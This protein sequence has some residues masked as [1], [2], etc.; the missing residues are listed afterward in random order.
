MDE[1]EETE[2]QEQTNED[3]EVGPPLLTPLSED[4]ILNE[5]TPWITR[6]SSRFIPHHAFSSIHSCLWW[7]AHAYATSR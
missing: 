1:T 5:V 4:A 6:L 7:G 2:E 3:P